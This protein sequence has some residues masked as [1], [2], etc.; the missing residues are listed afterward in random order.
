MLL[1]W[2][3]I[4]NKVLDSKNAARNKCQSRLVRALAWVLWESRRSALSA[5]WI[6]QV[7]LAVEWSRVCC[8][9]G[10]WSLDAD[11]WAHYKKLSLIRHLLNG[12]RRYL[13]RI[14]KCHSARWTLNFV[15]ETPVY[16]IGIIKNNLIY[17]IK[18][19][20]GQIVESQVDLYISSEIRARISCWSQASP[21]AAHIPEISRS[22]IS[23]LDNPYSNNHNFASLAFSWNRMFSIEGAIF[24]PLETNF[25]FCVFANEAV[26]EGLG[27]KWGWG[28]NSCSNKVGIARFVRRFE[29]LGENNKIS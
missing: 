20:R 26:L 25:L 23:D 2:P 5:R 16:T 29:G 13:D 10:V 17:C 27:R 24:P 1:I 7:L 18:N 9:E 19:W 4:N 6:F 12:I 22:K 21:W 14:K 15:I 3:L 28:M 8:W 11:N